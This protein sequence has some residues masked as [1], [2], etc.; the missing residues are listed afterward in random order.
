MLSNQDSKPK[1]LDSYKLKDLL[2]IS[3]LAKPRSHSLHTFV[4]TV[5]GPGKHIVHLIRHAARLGHEAH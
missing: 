3:F 4:Q 1:Q 5:C 2:Q